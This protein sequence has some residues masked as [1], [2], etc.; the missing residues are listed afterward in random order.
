M[1]RWLSSLVGMGRTILPYGLERDTLIRSL[2]TT[3]LV[4]SILV[5]CRISV[6]FGRSITFHRMSFDWLAERINAIWYQMNPAR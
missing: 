4:G 3:L 1:E 2:K 6:R 5:V